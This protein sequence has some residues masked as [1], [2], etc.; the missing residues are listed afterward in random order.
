MS[1]GNILLALR[2]D[3][4]LTAKELSKK[5]N[6]SINLIYEW[7]KGRCEPSFDCLIKI[8]EYFGVS[9][10]YLLGLEDDLGIKAH[11][12]LS[13]PAGP[14][15]RA[16]ISED[17]KEILSLFEKLGPFERS[18]MMIQLRALAEEHD[19]EFDKK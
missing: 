12:H 3:N 1:F 10:D 18:T 8:A 5:L 14:G 6:V 17:E 16:A 11:A 19:K 15:E 9:T 7:E 4:L 2:K 13:A